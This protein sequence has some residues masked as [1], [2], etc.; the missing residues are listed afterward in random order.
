[1]F[2]DKGKTMTLRRRPLCVLGS[3]IRIQRI[4]KQDIREKRS[5]LAQEA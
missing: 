5:F 2:P 1:M 3:P 4:R